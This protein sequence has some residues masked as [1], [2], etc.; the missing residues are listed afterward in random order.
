MGV[1]PRL[2]DRRRWIARATLYIARSQV[3]RNTTNLSERKGARHKRE[4][5][6]IASRVPS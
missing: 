1:E 5:R 4:S 6:K 2:S 3:M